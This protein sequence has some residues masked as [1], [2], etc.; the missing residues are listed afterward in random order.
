MVKE[1]EMQQVLQD[2]KTNQYISHTYTI[3]NKSLQ[4]QAKICLIAHTESFV[5]SFKQRSS[6]NV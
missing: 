3:I 2:L 1:T 6:N 4:L 5:G